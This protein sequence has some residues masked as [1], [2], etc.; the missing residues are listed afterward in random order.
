[1]ERRDHGSVS[2]VGD[3]NFSKVGNAV[4]LASILHG[5]QLF[6]SVDDAFG[7]TLMTYWLA[8]WNSG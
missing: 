1:M 4:S 2:G 6:S 8:A 5:G 3:S 7:A